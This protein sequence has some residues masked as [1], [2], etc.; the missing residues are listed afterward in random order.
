MVCFFNSAVIHG[1]SEHFFCLSSLLGASGVG[2]LLLVGARLP[3]KRTELAGAG[4]P[5]II[6]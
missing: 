2:T 5:K 4:G 6:Q 1:E 3:W